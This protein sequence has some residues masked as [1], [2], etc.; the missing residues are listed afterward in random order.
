MEKGRIVDEIIEA[1]TVHTYIENESMYPEVRD[2]APDPRY[3]K[4]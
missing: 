2:L 4:N 3:E 1:L